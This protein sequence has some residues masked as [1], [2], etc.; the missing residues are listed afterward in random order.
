[1]NIII[2]DKFP[3]ERF[4]ETVAALDPD[5]VCLIIDTNVR[6]LL[7]PELRDLPA[8]VF[9]AGE[10]SKTVDTVAEVWSRL[11]DI[12]ISRRSLIVNVG[13]GVVTDLGGFAAATFK[14]GVRFLNVPTTLLGAVDASIGGKTGVDFRGLKNLVGAFA[15]PSATI[16]PTDF[17]ETLPREELLSGF[18]EMVK[19][20]YISS[21]EL[22]GALLDVTDNWCSASLRRLLPEVLAV[23]ERVVAE[24]PHEKGLRRILNFG[25]TAA[26][27][28]EALLFSRGKSVAH[29]IA[30]AHGILIALILSHTQLSLPS[31]EIYRYADRLLR[32]VY[33]LIPFT[34]DDYDFLLAAMRADKK[35]FGASAEGK[36]A[37]VRFVLLSEI[38][39]PVESVPVG[40]DEILAA[41]DIYRDLIHS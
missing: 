4:R 37:P 41:L 34:C 35:N 1:M 32:P 13:G 19:C 8:A 38:G 33:P 2:S 6:E 25:H 23:K 20:G 17:W 7:P 16:I 5:K 29:G 28:F 21:P 24:D 27:A 10:A 14:R 31:D 22:T 39:K 9:P 26:H 36:S 11:L 3:V 12:G 30:V 18:A 40:D 15:E